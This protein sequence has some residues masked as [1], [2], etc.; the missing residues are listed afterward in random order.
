MME[1]LFRYCGCVVPCWG[2]P[3]EGE[4]GTGTVVMLHNVVKDWSGTVVIAVFGRPG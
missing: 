3:V 4:Y 1:H 2:G